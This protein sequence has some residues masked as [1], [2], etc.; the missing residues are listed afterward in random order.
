MTAEPVELTEA[1][2]LLARFET[3]MHRAEG[4]AYLSEALL[5]LADIRAD[6]ECEKMRQVASNVSLAYAKNVQARVEAL[7]C[8]EP[9]VHCETVEHWQKVFGEFERSGFALSQ[10]V[11]ETRSRLVMKMLDREIA[12]MSPAERAELIE[13]LKQL[14]TNQASRSP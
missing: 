14:P 2:A 12:V 7:L 5:L 9:S 1:R 8:S 3:E 4:L 6:A 13:R 10:D 11:A